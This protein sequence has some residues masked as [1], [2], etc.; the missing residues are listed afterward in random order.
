MAALYTGEHASL[1][2]ERQWSFRGASQTRNLC[3]LPRGSWL[4]GSQRLARAG[5]QTA[6]FLFKHHAATP[7]YSCK[8]ALFVLSISHSFFLCFLKLKN[9]PGRKN[10]WSLIGNH[11]HQLQNRTKCLTQ[12]KSKKKKIHTDAAKDP[13]LKT[14]PTSPTSACWRRG[15]EP[16]AREGA[17]RSLTGAPSRGP[18][19]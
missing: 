15:A 13:S 3:E 19:L 14:T 17:P 6:L 16:P 12:Q 2:G 18:Q 7:N 10:N 5:F 8:T 1:S 9:E 11:N 4:A